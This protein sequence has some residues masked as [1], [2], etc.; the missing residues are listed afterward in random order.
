MTFRRGGKSDLG[1]VVKPDANS[2]RSWAMWGTPSWMGPTAVRDWPK[3][4]DWN[5]EG[6]P[7]EP[8]SKNG[9]WKIFGHHQNEPEREEHLDQMEFNGR[10]KHITLVHWKP[11]LKKDDSKNVETMCRQRWYNQNSNFERSRLRWPL[12]LRLLPRSG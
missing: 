4:Q 8:R 11:S 9:P 10:I 7:S 3:E 12:N 6:L 1:Y 5:I 2:D